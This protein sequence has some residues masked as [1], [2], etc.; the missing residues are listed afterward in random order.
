MP[1][2]KAVREW[3]L[4]RTWN[5]FYLIYNYNNERG[6]EKGTNPIIMLYR[7]WNEWVDQKREFLLRSR[8]F[9]FP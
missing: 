7:L 4:E 5:V 2:R 8:H 1:R 3:I 9:F 6:E